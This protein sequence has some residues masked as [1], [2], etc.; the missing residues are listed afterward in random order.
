MNLRF[1]NKPC[2]KKNII[3]KLLPGVI[4]GSFLISTSDAQATPWASGPGPLAYTTTQGTF[5]GVPTSFDTAFSSFL[6]DKQVKILTTSAL[7]TENTVTFEYDPVYSQPWR[8]NY[9]TAGTTAN[10]GFL[11]YRITLNSSQDGLGI[12]ATYGQCGPNFVLG[13]ASPAHVS[14]GFV[15][16][17]YQASG[18]NGDDPGAL[19]G[20]IN[21][22]GSIDLSPYTDLYVN[23]SW[24]QL[25]LTSGTTMGYSQVPAPLPILGT[26]AFFGSVRRI[27]QASKRL[28]AIPKG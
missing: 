1:L 21:G 24:N 25:Q 8:V 12:C 5:G 16:K 22:S 10:P 23:V 28:R 9:L 20:Q 18:T 2:L 26:A 19:I 17:F 3:A 4:F 13:T 11:N 14:D 27:G 6:G 7:P 15:Q